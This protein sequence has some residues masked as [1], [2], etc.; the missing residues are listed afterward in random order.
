VTKRWSSTASF[1]GRTKRRASKD[2]RVLARKELKLVDYLLWLDTQ[3]PEASFSSG[4][5]LMKYL[6]EE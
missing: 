2:A 1:D 5:D 4:A 3:P 6:D